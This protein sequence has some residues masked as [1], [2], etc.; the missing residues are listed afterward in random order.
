VPQTPVPT[1]MK[2]IQVDQFGGVDHLHYR[3]IAVPSP[4]PYDVLVK[5]A[6]AG[7]GPWDAWI[8]SGNSV[9]KQKL[10][11]TPGSDIAG[12]VVAVGAAVDD[13]RPG[14]EVFG[15]TNGFFTGGYAEYAV[16]ERG[17]IAIRPSTLNTTEA[18]SIPV[19]AVTAWQMLF[20]HAQVR[21]GQ[22]VLVLG[23]AG[24]VGSFAVQLASGAGAH[25]LATASNEDADLVRSLGASEILPG[26]RPLPVAL[27]GSIDVVIDTVG[28]DLLG[29]A[30]AL[31]RRGGS[32]I[33][34]VT[35][36]DQ[37][38]SEEL[39]ITS[40]FILVDVHQDT[41]QELA[42]LFDL[43]KLRS[44][45]GEVLPLA[46]ARKAHQMLD[47]LPHLKGKIVLLP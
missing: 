38:R 28:S 43:G 8:R 27:K 19:V 30:Y 37:S 35:G 11:L 32:M 25:V 42:G 18:A 34:A 6:A 31:V 40:R 23:G 2:A 36:P 3:D 47:G 44:R 33:S 45:V 5:V 46:E 39:G 21:A 20:T 15:V 10:P 22:R 17:R 29:Q 14:D 13:V 16:A 26:R 12:T 7:V 41:L 24:S 4:G 1:Y 9:L